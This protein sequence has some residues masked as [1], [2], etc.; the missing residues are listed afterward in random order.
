MQNKFINFWIWSDSSCIDWPLNYVAAQYFQLTAF[1]QL[2][3]ECVKHWSLEPQNLKTDLNGR[4]ENGSTAQYCELY[5]T[6]MYVKQNSYR[7]WRKK[8]R[9]QCIKHESRRYIDSFLVEMQILRCHCYV[10]EAWEPYQLLSLESELELKIDW[11]VFTPYI[12]WDKLW[13]FSANLSN[14]LPAHENILFIKKV[15]KCWCSKP[16]EVLESPSFEIL[17]CHQNI[18]LGNLV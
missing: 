5:I 14:F 2:L 9:E 13:I 16:R 15:V 11:L 4:Q 1:S 3:Q 10:I 12:S 8:E 17:N 7:G 6:E 18:V